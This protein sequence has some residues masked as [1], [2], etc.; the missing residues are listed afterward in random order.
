MKYDPFQTREEM[1]N[2][3]RKGTSSAKKRYEE[4]EE[5]FD[6]YRDDNEEEEDSEESSVIRSFRKE[7]KEEKK[8]KQKVDAGTA[9][10]LLL[11]V[12]AL[13]YMFFANKIKGMFN[14]SQTNIIAYS[15]QSNSVQTAAY[16]GSSDTKPIENNQKKRRAAS[17]KNTDSPVYNFSKTML[18]NEAKNSDREGFSAV[19]QQLITT[20]PSIPEDDDFLDEE[21]EQSLQVEQD[22]NTFDDKNFRNNLK[23]IDQNM[24]NYF[25]NNQTAYAL[26]EENNS[27]DTNFESDVKQFESGLKQIDQKMDSYFQKDYLTPDFSE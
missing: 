17:N 7:Q 6:L 26:P 9:A 8:K 5:D 1:R 25:Q 21:L 22:D 2:M 19:P 27:K 13:G 23:Q 4:D 11:S 18:Q 15:D 16:S 3:L 24:E 14:Y 20:N 10:L 12:A